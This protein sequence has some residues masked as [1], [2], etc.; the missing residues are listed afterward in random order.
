MATNFLDKK[1]LTEVLRQISIGKLKFDGTL[2]WKSNSDPNA[3]AI[4]TN[5]RPIDVGTS[6]IQYSSDRRL[7]ENIKNIKNL[8][9]KVNKT[10]IKTFNYISKPEEE[11]VG[12]IARDIQENFADC[13]L[14]KFLVKEDENGMLSVSESKFVYV[15]W[16]AFNEYVEKTDKI[17]NELKEKIETLEKGK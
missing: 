2:S 4:D 3:K 16:G 15:L 5:S 6:Y 8:L 10:D 13:G 17:I 11:C 12:V 9:E 14:D 7:K 1:G